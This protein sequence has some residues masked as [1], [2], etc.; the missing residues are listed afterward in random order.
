VCFDVLL[1]VEG[2]F[3]ILFCLRGDFV[4][5]AFT[6]KLDAIVADAAVASAAVGTIVSGSDAVVDNFAGLK[7]LVDELSAFASLMKSNTY[8]APVGLIA[9]FG[10]VSG[11]VPSGWLLCAGQAVSQTT[12][13]DLFAVVGVNAFGTDAGGNFYLPDLRG[14]V[15]AGIDNMGGTDAGRLSLANTM[16]TAGG[17]ET[18]PEHLHTISGSG[19]TSG[20]D[21]N[22]VYNHYSPGSGSAAYPVSTSEGGGRTI[23]GAGGNHTHTYSFSGNSG[24]TGTG[25]HGVVQPTMVLNYIIKW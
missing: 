11:Q 5:N 14:R 6:D 7:D 20:S 15:V 10:G 2:V 21:W 19:T 12:Y 24:N 9:P 4:A 17:A 3:F 18:L 16:G 1:L 25:T 13:A 23:Q 8:Y 22:A